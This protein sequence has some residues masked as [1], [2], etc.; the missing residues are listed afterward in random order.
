[1]QMYIKEKPFRICGMAFE[2][3]NIALLQII[4]PNP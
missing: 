2:I 4:L 3:N 1:M